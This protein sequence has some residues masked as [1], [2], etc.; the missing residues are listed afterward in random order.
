MLKKIAIIERVA[1]VSLAVL[2][3]DGVASLARA[4]DSVQ[5]LADAIRMRFGET[6]GYT[7]GQLGVDWCFNVESEPGYAYWY[8]DL[9]DGLKP[10][11]VRSGL[12]IQ[13]TY[14]DEADSKVKYSSVFLGIAI[15]DADEY[16]VPFRPFGLDSPSLAFKGAKA[17]ESDKKLAEELAKATAAAGGLEEPSPSTTRCMTFAQFVNGYTLPHRLEPGTV[18]DA[19]KDAA[20]STSYSSARWW[21]F[22]GR[23]HG[24]RS[25]TSYD[26]TLQ[27][28]DAKGMENPVSARLIVGFGG[29]A[30]F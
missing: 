15:A 8:T 14:T 16:S 25:V 11:K 19:K 17:N 21:T 10:I 24:V 1:A 22:A 23:P 27:V 3:I 29:G 20:S 30:G 7:K 28:K 6:A 5:K 13:A 18:A 12:R 2:L 4:G 26:I 9:G